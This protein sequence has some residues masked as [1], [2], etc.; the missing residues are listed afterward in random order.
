MNDRTVSKWTLR[1]REEGVESASRL[2]EVA[3]YDYPIIPVRPTRPKKVNR[4]FTSPPP[5]IWESAGHVELSRRPVTLFAADK[6]EIIGCCAFSF[7]VLIVVLAAL[8][9]P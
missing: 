6:M 8:I 3:A 2:Q 7:A 5:E 4:P 9:T 1:F